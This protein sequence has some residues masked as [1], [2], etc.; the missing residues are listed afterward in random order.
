MTKDTKNTKGTSKDVSTDSTSTGLDR[1]YDYATRSFRDMDRL[2]RDHE[3]LVSR[4]F[5]PFR[6]EFPRVSDFPGFEDVNER[7]RR[8][9]NED[10]TMDVHI[11]LPGIRKEDVKVAV[12]QAEVDDVLTV[13][14]SSHDGKD[15]HLSYSER[16][17]SVSLPKGVEPSDITSKLE[18]GLLRIHIPAVEGGDE[19]EEHVVTVE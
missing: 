3:S 18:S 19:P 7:I 11:D 13:S 15:D 10:G 2:F 16:S 14:V 9:H 8:Y 5:N 12:K 4:F 6:F 17:Y 1:S